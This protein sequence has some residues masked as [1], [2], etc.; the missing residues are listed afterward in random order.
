MGYFSNGTEGDI[1]S[2]KYCEKCV[3]HPDCAVW[4]AHLFHS[5]DEVNKPNSILHDLIPIDGYAENLKCV[6]FIEGDK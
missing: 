5:S 6:M 4:R 3:H 2:E 1:Y